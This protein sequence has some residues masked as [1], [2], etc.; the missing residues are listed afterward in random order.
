MPTKHERLVSEVEK[1]KKLLIDNESSSSTPVIADPSLKK[2]A[3]KHVHEIEKNI[4][5]RTP[6]KARDPNTPTQFK[7]NKPVTDAMI[8]FAGWEPKSEHSRIDITNAIHKYIVEH[9]L[10]IPTCK[11]EFRIDSKLKKLLKCTE[12]TLTY[13]KLQKYISSQFLPKPTS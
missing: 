1:L 3:V 11:R 2:Q 6:R 4:S 7:V 9:E 8:A 13:P 12:P 10:Q 5:S